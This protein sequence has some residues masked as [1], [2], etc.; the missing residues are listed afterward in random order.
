MWRGRLAEAEGRRCSHSR[1]FSRIASSEPDKLLLIS[2]LNR[3][4]WAHRFAPR[5]SRPTES[6][7]LVPAI[8]MTKAADPRQRNDCG[9]VASLSFDATPI[10]S[11]LA[12]PVGTVKK[13]IATMA[14][15]WFRG[16]LSQRLPGS[17]RRWMARMY[18]DTDRCK[19]TSP[20]KMIRYR[21][22]SFT[23][24][25][26]RSAYAF[27]LG[28]RAGSLIVFTPAPAS[29]SRNSRVK[30]HD[31]VSDISCF[32]GILRLH[33]S[34]SPPPGQSTRRPGPDGFRPR[35]RASSIV[36]LQK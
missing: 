6:G 18:R 26:K 27:R 21:Q 32:V 3:C 35:E 5:W 33:L 4:S 13:S 20:N 14:S 10:G 9:F 30:D 29:T 23:V 7:S 34:Y 15:R 17:P 28:E 8:T 11:V 2:T 25:T 1:K 16:K 24:R 12:E 19:P 31:H 22:D 36:R